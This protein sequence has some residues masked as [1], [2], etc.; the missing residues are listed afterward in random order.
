MRSPNFWR[1]ERDSNPRYAFDVHTISSRAR[2]DR[3]DTTPDA[4]V[5]GDCSRFGQSAVVRSSLIIILTIPAFVN[6][7][8]QILEDS[9]PTQVPGRIVPIPLHAKNE[10][11]QFCFKSRLTIA[12][13]RSKI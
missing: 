4:I 11:I 1:S 10:K 9:F 3:F 8:F 12:K 13:K 5:R 7:F 6:C 2:Y